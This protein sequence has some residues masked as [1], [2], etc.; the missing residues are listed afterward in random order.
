MEIGKFSKHFVYAQKNTLPNTAETI[1]FMVLMSFHPDLAEN[2]REFVGN[3]NVM[4]DFPLLAA[5]VWGL[6]QKSVE[7]HFGIKEKT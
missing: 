7:E 1:K 2:V 5:L 6:D 3:C 4:I